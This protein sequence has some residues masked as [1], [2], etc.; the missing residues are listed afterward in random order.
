VTR[1]R[2][3]TE[4]WFQI[5]FAAGYAAFFALLMLFAI[6]AWKWKSGVP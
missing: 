3:T 2:L 1:R 6:A 4:E 5:G